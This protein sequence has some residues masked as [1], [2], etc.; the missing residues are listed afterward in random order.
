MAESQS[1]SGDGYKCSCG[2]ITDTKAK[3]LSHLAK[4]G[5]FAKR[6]SIENL[7]KSEGRVNIITGE[8]TMP[9]WTQRTPQQQAASLYSKRNQKTSDNRIINTR[10]TDVLSSASEIRFI[11]RIFSTTYTPIMHQAQDASIRWFG[12]PQLAFE[13]FLD[14]VLVK[15]FKMWGVELGTYKVADI[16]LQES[17]LRQNEQE[18]PQEQQEQDEIQEIAV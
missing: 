8:I 9:P 16:L 15:A 13:D 14:T 5:R 4:E 3:F 18:Q 7:H 1:Q 17:S 10:S 2:F 11:P 6:G 12:W